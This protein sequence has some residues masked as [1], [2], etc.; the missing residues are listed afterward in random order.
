MACNL[1]ITLCNNSGG[2]QQRITLGLA[3]GQGAR[4]EGGLKSLW[5]LLMA[6]S[7][8][9]SC[10]TTSVRRHRALA[11]KQRTSFQLARVL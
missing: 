1:Y 3:W 2:Q 9:S 11:S 4:I 6:S 7:K 8:F 10:T 5:A